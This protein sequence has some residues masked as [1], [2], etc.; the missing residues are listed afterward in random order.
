MSRQ[1][2]IFVELA[3][4]RCFFPMSW[5]LTISDVC[6]NIPHPSILT[7]E[8]EENWRT[9][10]YNSMERTASLPLKR[11]LCLTH[12]RRGL[13]SK[14]SI[15]RFPCF[16]PRKSQAHHY[17]ESLKESH[18]TWYFSDSMLGSGFHQVSVSGVKLRFGSYV[19]LPNEA[20]T[21][22]CGKFGGWKPP[23]GEIGWED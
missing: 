11:D 13:F 17:R 5:Y 19:S 20:W 6:E 3:T 15:F 2:S 22:T 21:R 12:F 9:K 16:S 4:P 23:C 14:P 18:K 8:E 10:G 1:R 7:V